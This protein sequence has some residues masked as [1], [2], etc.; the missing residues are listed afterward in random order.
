MSRNDG[1]RLERILP[2][3][4]RRCHGASYRF[5]NRVRSLFTPQILRGASLKQ[6]NRGMGIYTA[7]SLTHQSGPCKIF[8]NPS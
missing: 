5:P 2:V 1:T 8:L 3:E 6:T 4:F 7:F